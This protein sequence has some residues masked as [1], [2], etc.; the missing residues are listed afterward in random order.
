M[1]VCVC[2]C[3]YVCVCLFWGGG[4][5]EEPCQKVLPDDPQIPPAPLSHKNEPSLG[6]CLTRNANPHVTDRLTSATTTTLCYR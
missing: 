3:V 5:G 1:C 4:G 6:Y 2:V